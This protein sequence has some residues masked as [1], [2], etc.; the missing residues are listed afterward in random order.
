[1][2]PLLEQLHDIE[3]LD[4]ISAWPL[5]LG[6]WFVIGIGTATTV[7][8]CYYIFKRVVFRYS[9]KYDTLRKLELLEEQLCDQTA[10]QTLVTLSEYLR[11]IAIKRY[12]RQTCASLN[13]EAWLEW[14]KKTDP[15]QY[16]WTKQGQIL[17]DLPYAPVAVFTPSSRISV[18]RERLDVAF[19]DEGIALAIAEEKSAADDLLAGDRKLLEGGHTA[20][21]ANRPL[22][23][24]QVQELIQAVKPWVR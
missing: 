10:R 5:A 19:C 9:W 24:Q 21:P 20:T 12:S 15:H 2:N 13:G 3:G 4:P 8:L 17:I 22:S 6:W 23:S 14:L 7:L 16:D 11:R 1:M 18:S